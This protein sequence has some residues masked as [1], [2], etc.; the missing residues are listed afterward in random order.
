MKCCVDANSHRPIWLFNLVDSRA[1]QSR[2]EKSTNESKTSCKSLMFLL[3]TFEF[4][5]ELCLSYNNT[6]ISTLFSSRRWQPK[7]GHTFDQ[8]QMRQPGKPR[9]EHWLFLSEEAPRFKED[10]SRHFHH[11]LRLKRFIRLSSQLKVFTVNLLK[12][13]VVVNFL[14]TS[15]NR[16][17]SRNFCH[18][19]N[20]KSFLISFILFVFL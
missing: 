1:L 18:D 9:F 13:R 20:L 12:V 2:R 7:L 8:G 19:R 11:S 17:L 16:K 3:V 5:L 15:G 6:W 14:P 10:F 4:F